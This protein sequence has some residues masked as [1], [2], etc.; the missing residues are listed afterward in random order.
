MI[1]KGIAHGRLVELEDHVILPEGTRVD[2]VV[3]QGEVEQRE[4]ITPLRGSP[5]VL[6]AELD[7]AP[8]CTSEDVDLLMQA[9]AQGRLPTRVEGP[10]DRES[11][12][13]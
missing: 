11:P 7:V 6:L 1:Y 3:R 13:P 2:I 4:Q 8:G 12:R 10:F 9:I 5:Q